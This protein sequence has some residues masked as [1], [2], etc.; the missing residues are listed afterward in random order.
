[1]RRIYAGDSVLISLIGHKCS[2][3]R[4]TAI[5]FVNMPLTFMPTGR[6]PTEHEEQRALVRNFRKCFD[7]MIFAIPNGG[8]RSKSQGAKLKA[9]G[10]LPG[11]PDLFIPG[12][13]LWIEM[14]PQGKGSMSKDQKK[15]AI[16][17]TCDGYHVACCHGAQN[18]A[19]YIFEYLDSE[20]FLRD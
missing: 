8:H 6:A 11:I 15:Q 12:W 10:V 7:T 3:K 1:M 2:I 17:L 13:A 18:A 5:E 4:E 16:D 20:G 19:W 14:K 9:E